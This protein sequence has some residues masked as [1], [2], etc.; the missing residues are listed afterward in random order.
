MQTKSAFW[1][2]AP[3]GAHRKFLSADTAITN[4]VG[5]R[6]YG[7]SLREAKPLILTLCSSSCETDLRLFRRTHASP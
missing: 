3:A 1:F 4:I 6:A 7:T 5:I 2:L